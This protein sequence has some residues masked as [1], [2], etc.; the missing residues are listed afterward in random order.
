MCIFCAGSICQG[1]GLCQQVVYN[2]Y[3]WVHYVIMAGLAA[4]GG[5]IKI[6]WSYLMSFFKM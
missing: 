4:V 2:T 3:Y 6:K 1:T 5:F